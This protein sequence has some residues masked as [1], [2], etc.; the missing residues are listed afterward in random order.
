MV[1]I[2]CAAL[3]FLFTLSPGAWARPDPKAPAVAAKSFVLTLARSDFEL[4]WN[5][6][7]KDSQDKIA[8]MTIKRYEDLDEVIYT[9]PN[10]KLLLLTNAE[11]HRTVMF[12]D[13]TRSWCRKI[14]IKPTQLKNVRAAVVKGNRKNA[15]V[16]LYFGKKT[17]T[18]QM[19]NEI[20]WKDNWRAVW[21]PSIDRKVIYR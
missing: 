4:S 10:M 17:A 3:I 9:L 11:G 7:T 6:V 12:E 1:R 16:R 18:L 15:V 8:L 13:M 21:H 19:E 14:G 5:G 2:L 20:D